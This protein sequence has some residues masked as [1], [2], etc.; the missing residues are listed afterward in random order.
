MEMKNEEYRIQI[1]INQQSHTY[2]ENNIIEIKFFVYLMNYIVKSIK[3]E[4]KWKIIRKIY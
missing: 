1:C 2:I 3:C 4:I